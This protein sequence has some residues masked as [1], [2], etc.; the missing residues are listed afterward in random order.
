MC[1]ISFP[2]VKKVFLSRVLPHLVNA[3]AAVE[4]NPT[5]VKSGF[6]RAG[7]YPPDP[8]AIN[9]NACAPS[10]KFGG[11]LGGGELGE[12]ELGEGELGEGELGE[13]ARGGYT[14][15]NLDGEGSDSVEA[16]GAQKIDLNINLN[17]AARKRKYDNY[18]LSVLDADE[19]RQ[20]CELYEEGYRDSTE[21][22]FVA[23]SL[24]RS[25]AEVGAFSAA[26]DAVSRLLPTSFPTSKRKKT[27]RLPDGRDR[28]D[29]SG[30]AWRKRREE[31]ANKKEEKAEKEEEKRR[32][33]ADRAEAAALKKEQQQMKKAEKEEAKRR[34]AADR[35]QATALK[36]ELRKGSGRKRS[37]VDT[38]DTLEQLATSRIKV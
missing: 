35:A 28:Y 27:S 17:L 9:Y 37:L 36:K 20:F 8:D 24:L 21:E 33:A 15:G 26:Q 11:E 13:Q 23:Y 38:L 18:R 19:E 3:L 29:P 34:K 12:G 10:K 31:E 16:T 2:V 32:Q 22:L 5:A 7:I 14:S 6:R 1:T 25:K 30:E 4:K